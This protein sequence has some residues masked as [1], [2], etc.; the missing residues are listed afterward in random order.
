MSEQTKPQVICLIPVKNERWIL[1]RFLRCASVWADRIIVADQGSDD[2][3]D[4]IAQRYPKV[5]LVRNTTPHNDEGGRQRLLIDH[6]RR[7]PGPRLLIALDADEALTANALGSA[8]WESVLAARP[9][10]VIYI[11]WANLKP[12]L[13]T[14][15]APIHSSPWGFMDDGS[16]HTGRRIHSPRV[17]TPAGAPEIR[18]RKI[19]VLHYQ[20]T[21]WSRMES[22]HRWYQCWERLNHGKR[23]P[24]EIY[25]EYHHMDA[26]P[27]S[28]LHPVPEAWTKAYQDAGIDMHTV[29]FENSYY[30]DRIV[31]E[32]FREHGTATFQREAI[33]DVDWR[34]LADRLGASEL[35]EGADDP[36]SRRYKLLHACL[37]KTQPL[38]APGRRGVFRRALVRG[39]DR[40]LRLLAMP[41][42]RRR[43]RRPK[44]STSSSSTG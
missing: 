18:L 25:R 8:E 34:D 38:F 37:K 30:W 3:S 29:E 17:P 10:T 23:N 7:V 16:P 21:D 41:P 11:K 2:G 28:D 32:W 19:R 12:D 44:A 43:T 40:G 14:Y 4:E 5:T 24:I 13:R 42:S 39:L 35:A 27:D 36:R 6:A 9:G 22:K 1:D 33:W 20:Y 31:L 26:I 15:W